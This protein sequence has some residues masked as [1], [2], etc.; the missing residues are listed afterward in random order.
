MKSAF[1]RNVHQPFVL[2]YL[3]LGDQIN[4]QLRHSIE[5]NIYVH[6]ISA[7]LT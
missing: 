6:I 5:G 1:V 2:D 3:L 7:L 4:E